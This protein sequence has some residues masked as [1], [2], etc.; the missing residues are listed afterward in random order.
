[1]IKVIKDDI[2]PVEVIKKGASGS[3]DFRDI[4]SGVNDKFYRNSW[5]EFKDL[6]NID[7]KYYATDFYDISVYKYDVKC[8]TSLIFLESKG[9]INKQDSYSWF[10]IGKEEDLKMIKDKLVDGKSC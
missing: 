6:E 3:T 10:H 8:G 2:S 1:M 9:W 4:Y 5:K 7:K